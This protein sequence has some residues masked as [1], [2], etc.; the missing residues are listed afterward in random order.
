VKET[1]P[2]VEVG[3]TLSTVAEAERDAASFEGEGVRVEAER[4]AASFEGEGVRVEAE[5]DTMTGD[6]DVV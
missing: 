2:G 5:R 4:D 3:D 6:D 1:K